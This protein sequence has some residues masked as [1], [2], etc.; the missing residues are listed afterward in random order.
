MM[1]HLIPIL[2][3]VTTLTAA[4][5]TVS[6]FDYGLR[7]AHG[8]MGR[9]YALY[10]AHVDAFYRG[11]EVSYD[12]IDT[13]EIELP[14]NWKSIPLGHH[15]DFGG[16]VLYVTNRNKH[17]ALF[18]L[19]GEEKALQLDKSVV[20][21]RR[22]GAIPELSMGLKLLVLADQHPWTERRGY[23][24]K[25]YRRDLM[26][27]QDG[28]SVNAPI[29]SWNTDSTDLKAS[30]YEA[31][32][33]RKVFRGLTM[34]RTKESTY[35]TYCISVQ[36]Q[37][38]VWIEDIHITTPKSKMIADGVFSV[39]NS[40][41]IN[42]LDVTVDGT[43]SGYGATRDYGYAF[44]LNNVWFAHFQRVEAHG[45]WGVFGSNNLSNTQL[46]DCNLD[47]FDIHCYGR[48]AWLVRCTLRQRQTQF[49]SMFGTVTYDSCH[50]I[51]CIPLRIRS[52]YNAYTPF[53]IVMNDC[54]F[55]LTP[56]YHSIVNV[57]LLDTADNPR[58]ELSEKCWPNLT[59]NRMT[60]VVPWTVGSINLFHPTGTLSELRRSFGYIS[61]V[62]VGGMK[63]VRPNGAAVEVPLHLSSR[64]FK[65]V[66][67]LKF[68]VE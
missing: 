31:D 1:K 17:G 40:A 29:A 15:T 13:L 5:Q 63:M 38:N 42:F 6:P 4:A 3:M 50:F 59:V 18:S 27:V 30:Y 2:L 62:Y 64:K 7:E 47:R 52:S 11:L 33:A 37:Y 36:G 65:T 39:R 26:V 60:V 24:Y 14:P 23:G 32:T 61:E 41:R 68:T 9:Y 66:N 56:R 16:L 12:G 48:D 43:Y 46:F 67:E 22:F 28:W 45:N 49:S 35:K 54:T 58:P 51:D 44:S 10:N 57:L 34:H 21:G 20:D 25:Q 8:P 53:D 19:V 55:E